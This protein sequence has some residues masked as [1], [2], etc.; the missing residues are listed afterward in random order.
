M[1]NFGA[2]G[3][4]YC[5]TAHGCAKFAPKLVCKSS[6]MKQRW[7]IYLLIGFLFGVFDFYYHD[8][9]SRIT[10]G[11]AWLSLSLGIW[12]IPTIPVALYEAH[13]SRS[14]RRSAAA[15][16]L[17]WCTALL[18]YYLANIAQ[19]ALIG[20]S[21]WPD[22]HISHGAD[23]FFWQSWS[24]VF[25]QVIVA[26]IAEWMVVAVVGGFLVGCIASSIYLYLSGNKDS[27]LGFQ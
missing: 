26:G 21:D 2:I 5:P 22:L 13:T 25:W 3:I 7:T 9:I 12:L 24:K 8:F 1:Y 11:F 23:P 18:S 15:S 10:G 6:M 14:K 16:L 4:T 27:P 19:L 17:I 20:D